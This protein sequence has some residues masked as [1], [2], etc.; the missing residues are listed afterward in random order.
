MSLPPLPKLNL[1]KVRVMIVLVV[2]LL[3]VFSGGYLLGV[4]RY[5]LEV[6]KVGQVTLSRAIPLGKEKVDFALFWKVWDDLNA[7]YFDKTKINPVKMVYG[8]ISGMVASL[9]DPY[10]VFLPPE[11]NKLVKEDLN[12]SFDGVGI[13]I[14]FKGKQLTVI[15]P[16]PGTPAE[17]A[18]IKAGDG[19]IGIKDSARGVDMGT[20]G[21]S[22]P[23]AVEAIRGKKGTKVTLAILRDGVSEPIIVEVERGEINVPS[24]V[25][26][27]EEKD[28]QKIA[29]IKLLKFGGETNGEW[30][31]VVTKILKDTPSGIIL[32]LRNNPGGYL[33]G[34]VDIAGEFLPTKTLV[35][36]EE[37]ALGQKNEYQTSKLPRLGKYPL[38]VLVNKGSASASEI[39]AGALRDQAKIPIIGEVTFGKG[40]IQEPREL[41]QGS[42][43]HITI[44]KW[45][46]P[47][48]TWVNDKGLVPD[49]K[50][51]DDPNTPND[52][53]QEKAFEMLLKKGV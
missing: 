26:S 49:V 24:V 35:T 15:A 52:E 23:E 50:V 1:R 20:V 7:S 39:L 3:G 22:L 9:G 40:T 17:K 25:L 4:K 29:V 16:L 8:A 32:D 38:V 42:G 14:G 47:G 19:I 30:E 2:V 6:N 13:Q 31:K 48:G 12:G 37:N 5:R 46:T 10:T 53:Q 41:E 33:Q 34:A 11:E 44:A 21:I 36:Y 51:E 18:G 28:S 43:I 27:F 45:L